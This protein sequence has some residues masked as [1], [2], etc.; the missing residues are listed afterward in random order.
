MQ[1]AAELGAPL[2]RRMASRPVDW[3]AETTEDGGAVPVIA[4]SWEARL[5]SIFVMPAVEMLVAVRRG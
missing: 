4:T 1:T 2:P 5:A 3:M